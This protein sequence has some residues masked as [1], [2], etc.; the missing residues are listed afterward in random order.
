MLSGSAGMAAAVI[1]PGGLFIDKNKRKV[2]DINHF[3]VSPAHTHSSVTRGGPR[4]SLSLPEK[5][6][7]SPRHKFC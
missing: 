6:P 3:D 1:F 4:R 2:V 7:E 5:R